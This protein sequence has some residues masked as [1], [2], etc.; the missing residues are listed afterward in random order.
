MAP[1]KLDVERLRKETPGCSS[2]LVHL[3]N[4]GASLMPYAV[5]DAVKGHL[6]QEAA[7]GGYEAAEMAREAMEAFYRNAAAL[8]GG[9][10]EEIAFADSATRAWLSI[11]LAIDWRSGDEVITASS[12]YTSH[13]IAFRLAEQRQ[14]I[15]VRILPDQESGIVDPQALESLISPRTRLICISHMPTND[16]LINPV[17]EIGRIAGR[18]SIPFLLDACQSAGHLPLDVSQIQCTMLS[19]TGR[20][21]LRGPRGTGFLWVCSDWLERLKPAVADIMSARLTD[22][23][24]VEIAATARRFELWER[25]VADQIGLGAACGYAINIGQPA[26]WARIREL[27]AH[28]RRSLQAVP[29]VSVTDRGEEQ[30]GI[31]TFT[32]QRFSAE[33]IVARLREEVRINTSVSGVQP[34]RRDMIAKG[35]RTIIRASVH[36]YNT[37]DELEQLTEALKRLAKREM[38]PAGALVK[39]QQKTG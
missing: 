20:K 4:A 22:I 36:A 21:Y 14:G 34:T 11:F 25:S 31:V 16:G 35:V 17:A 37:T 39:Q 3:N 2:G 13:L 19:A 38:P 12:E 28:L 18:H 24:R 27:S 9:R 29:G 33:E 8:V 7:H 15:V 10:A 30:S 32:H 6:A 5:L 26:I 23:D 1:A